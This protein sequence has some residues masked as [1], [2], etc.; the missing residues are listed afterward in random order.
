MLASLILQPGCGSD[1]VLGQGAGDAAPPVAI[2]ASSAPPPAF[3]PPPADT[4]APANTEPCPA[5][6]LAAGAYARKL[7]HGGVGRT[8][9]VHVP[10]GLGPGEHIPIVLY[11]HP[12]GM[13][14]SYLRLRGSQKADKE[15]FVAVFP[16]GVNGSWNAGACCG[17]A[18]GASGKPPLDDVGFIRA[19]VADLSSVLCVDRRRVYATGFS[20]GGFLSHRLACEASDL[21]AAAVPVGSVNGLTQCQPKRPVPILMINGTADLLVPYQGGFSFPGITQGSFISV[22]QTMDGWLQRNGCSGAPEET[23]N[24]GSARCLTHGCAAG[25]K[26]AQCTVEGGGHCWYG[27][28]LCFV[29][30]NTTDIVVTDASWAFLRQFALP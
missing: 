30:K 16:D 9:D 14:K 29:G 24:K 19:V 7:T 15:R 3:P 27:D 12:L 28:L 21:V 20:N 22:S 1:E 11:L 25:A 18:N 6:P 17:P 8:Y 10:A 2:E 23:Y 4:P 5:Q 26:V 13:N